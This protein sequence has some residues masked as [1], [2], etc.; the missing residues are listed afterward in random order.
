MN[1]LYF[2]PNLKAKYK[3]PESNIDV[4]N[5]CEMIG[6]EI[7][8]VLEHFDFITKPEMAFRGQPFDRLCKRSGKWYIVEIKGAKHGFTGTL[9]H[10]QKRRMRQVLKKVKDLEPVLLQINLDAA[11]YKIRYGTEVHA[12]I[13]N[14]ERK[15]LQVNN[16]I[17]WVQDTISSHK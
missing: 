4:G 11:K 13:A 16:I 5:L 1:V 15:R 10:T 9:S 2:D 8:R 17:N 12:L 3:P 6:E 14:N 7:L